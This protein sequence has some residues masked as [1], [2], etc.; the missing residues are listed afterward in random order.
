VILDHYPSAGRYGV[1]RTHGFA[2]WVIRAGTR[3]WADHA[4]VTID[5]RGTIIEA[6][7][8]GVRK[9]YLGEYHGDKLMINAHEPASK[10]QLAKVAAAASGMIGVKYNDL[11]IIDDGFESLGVYW[12]WL[13]KLAAGD[14]EVICSQVAAVCGHAGGFDWLCGRKTYAEVTPADLAR[15]TDYLVDWIWS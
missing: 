1:V 11:A 3:S 13:A 6:E 2:P 5:D 8:G 14:H 9:G 4:F 12:R 10:D 7:P 15:R